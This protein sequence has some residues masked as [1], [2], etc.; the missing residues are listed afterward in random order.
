MLSSFVQKLARFTFAIVLAACCSGWRPAKA[1]AQEIPKA[2]ND[3]LSDAQA[4]A[5]ALKAHAEAA[6]MDR[7]PRFFYEVKSGKGDVATMR[8]SGSVLDRRTRRSARWSGRRAGLASMGRYPGMDREIRSLEHGGTRRPAL[9]QRGSLA[10]R[11][12]LDQ[13]VDLRA[14]RKRRR[15]GPL[16]VCAVAGRPLGRIAEESRLL[17]SIAASLLVGD[18]RSSR[19]Q[20]QPGSSCAGGLSV[21]RDGSIR[22]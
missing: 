4:K 17:A 12:G 22:R 16:L 3:R 10:K 1:I 5:L 6:A 11:S 14:Y 2:T 15:A 18:E 20:Y 9:S 13:R 21:C 8:E 19:R 7:L